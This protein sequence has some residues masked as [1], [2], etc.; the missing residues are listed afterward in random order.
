VRRTGYDA[1][2][3]RRR[4][5]PFPDDYVSSTRARVAIAAAVFGWLFAAMSCAPF[6]RVAPAA[7]ASA[8]ASNNAIVATLQGLDANL[9]AQRKRLMLQCARTATTSKAAHKCIDHV[10]ADH[11][12]VL[13]W[14]RRAEGVQHSLAD[15]LT[16]AQAGLAVGDSPNLA[17]VLALY[18]EL[19]R[20]YLGL[21]KAMTETR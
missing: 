13:A 1:R 6:G 17:R 19:Q 11:R 8:V 9:R 4:W 14:L 20:T 5:P 3:R 21:S 18:G 16:A 10:V 2:A 12:A 7:V 15:A